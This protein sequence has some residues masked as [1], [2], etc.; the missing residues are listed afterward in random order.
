MLPLCAHCVSKLYNASQF[1]KRLIIHG[2]RFPCLPSLLAELCLKNISTC[3]FNLN[4]MHI[5]FNIQ[6]ECHRSERKYSL[7]ILRVYSATVLPL[8][9]PYLHLWMCWLKLS[10]PL[11][12]SL[13]TFFPNF[14]LHDTCNVFKKSTSVWAWKK[15]ITYSPLVCLSQLEQI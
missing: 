9:E 8:S 12:E 4:P 10:I 13:I 5:G 1:N 15:I 7:Y 14:F 6:C 2:T 3:V 11:I